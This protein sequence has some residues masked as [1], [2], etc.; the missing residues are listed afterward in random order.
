[1][2]TH[3]ESPPASPPTPCHFGPDPADYV[4]DARSGRVPTCPACRAECTA[5]LAAR[6]RTL[7]A[8][9]ER[10]KTHAA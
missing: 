8:M 5:R 2:K 9:A 10:A 4:P 1:M 3:H 6:V 7:Q